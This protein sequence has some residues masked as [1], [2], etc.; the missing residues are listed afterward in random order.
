MVQSYL[1]LLKSIKWKQTYNRENKEKRIALRKD[2]YIDKF[3]A[4]LMKNREKTQIIN[5]IN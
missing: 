1:S 4:G 2:K 5:I 3:L